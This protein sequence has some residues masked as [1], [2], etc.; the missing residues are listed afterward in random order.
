MW[1][2]QVQP[3]NFLHIQNGPTFH[4]WPPL[5]SS[6][7]WSQAPPE[8]PCLFLCLLLFSFPG[9]SGCR[10]TGTHSSHHV[11]RRSPSHPSQ[12]VKEMYR[13]EEWFS[14]GQTEVGEEP[15]GMGTLPM[16][17]CFCLSSSLDFL[18][19]RDNHRAQEGRL[20][21]WMIMVSTGWNLSQRPFHHL[22]NSGLKILQDDQICWIWLERRLPSSPPCPLRNSSVY[23]VLTQ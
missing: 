15:W 1:A 18:D 22:V 13:E 17:T 3:L 9:V 16:L 19:Q 6:F 8:K 23:K 12:M 2:F 11:L 7:L 5:L 4:R 20:Q 10:Q 14:Q 21:Q